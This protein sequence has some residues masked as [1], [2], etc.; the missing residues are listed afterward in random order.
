MGLIICYD[1]G[2]GVDACG[3][4]RSYLI[5]DISKVTCKI[6]LVAIEGQLI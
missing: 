6:C 3:L 4:M 1:I 2:E 5:N